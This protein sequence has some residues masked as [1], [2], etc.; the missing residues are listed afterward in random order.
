MSLSHANNL[1]PAVKWSGSKRSQAE[2][3]VSRFP[4]EIDTYYEPFCGGCSVLNRLLHDSTVR[5]R[6]FIASDVNADLIALWNAIKANPDALCDRY[7]ERW[8]LFNICG[9]DTKIQEK[10]YAH[11]K[12]YFYKI[13]ECYNKTHAP[14]DFL[15]IMRT[16]TNGMPRYN[17]RGEFNNSCHF[18]RPGIEPARLRSILHDWSYALN[19][20][21]VEFRCSSYDAIRPSEN[22]FVYSDP[23]Y[24]ATKGMYYG[25]IDRDKFFG[26]LGTLPCGWALSFDGKAGGNDY[27]AAVPEG[28][29]TTH[30]YIPSGNSS[31]RRVIGNDRHAEVEESLYIKSKQKGEI[32]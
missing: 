3:I 26:W 4:R 18:S 20:A 15:F 30:E 29:Y 12:E 14:A 32:C 11:R 10:L 17:D 23:P 22:D 27:T 19:A 9:E 1:L 24:A 21:D 16:T 31:F 8:L 6:R 25:G 7:A 5:V 28:L 13:R 2:A